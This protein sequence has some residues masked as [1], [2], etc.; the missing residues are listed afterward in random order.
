MCEG[1][2]KCKNQ[3]RHEF[4]KTYINMDCIMSSGI[5]KCQIESRKLSSVKKNA[6]NM[7]KQNRSASLLDYYEKVSSCSEN[8]EKAYTCPFMIY[9]YKTRVSS[10]EFDRPL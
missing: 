3:C 9:H 4:S 2:V 7:L 1:I 6:V 10:L 8:V 5:V